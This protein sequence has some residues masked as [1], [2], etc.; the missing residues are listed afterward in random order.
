MTII[1]EK[2]VASFL[3]RLGT[4][5]IKKLL[6]ENNSTVLD[7][8]RISFFEAQ[9]KFHKKYG[10]KYGKEF[11]TFLADNANF[12]KFLT[13]F[14]FSK[15]ILSEND[16]SPKG[17]DGV[18]DVSSEI[19][20]DFIAMANAEFE[21][22]L[23]LKTHFGLQ[24]IITTQSADHSLL[25]KIIEAISKPSRNEL[26]QKLTQI[27]QIDI[28]DV[29][30]RVEELETVKKL[31]EKS[32]KLVLVNGLGGIGKTTMAKAF[33]E[34]YKNEFAHLVWINASP[35]LLDSVLGEISLIDNLD[36]RMELNA[37]IEQKKNGEAY[38]LLLNRMKR[39]E[40]NNLL[41][42]D[43]VH[44]Q[45]EQEL[46]ILTGHLA[47]TWKTLLTSRQE[48]PDCRKYPLDILTPD[49]AKE[50][51]LKH[52]DREYDEND[53]DNLLRHIGYHTLTIE[54]LSKTANKNFTL[55]IKTILEYLQ[56]H[57]LNHQQ[58]AL[59]IKVAHT[60][61]EVEVYAHLLS[62]FDLDQLNTNEQ[63]LLKQ[64]SLLPPI[65]IEQE[66]LYEY[67]SITEKTQNDFI[68]TLNSLYQKGF[69]NRNKNFYKA[70]QIIQE[71]ALYKFELSFEDCEILMEYFSGKLSLDQAKDNPVDK[72]PF[73]E[74]G[75]Y[76]YKNLELI[77]INKELK[78]VQCEHYSDFSSNLAAVYRDL[79]RYVQ[80]ADLFEKA[81]KSDIKNFGE[82]HP[83]IAINQSN[84]ATVYRDLGRYDQAADLFEK[85]LKSDIKNFGENHPTVAICQ[86]N[87]GAVYRDLG[88]YDQAVEL[89]EKA[90]QSDIKNFGENHPTV[91][92]CQ[93]N[94]ALVYKDLGRYYEAVKLIERVF[95]NSI[96]NFGENHPTVAV[97]R[98]NLATMYDSL[99]RY[100]QAAEL[101]ENALK[102]NITNLGENHPTVAIIRSNL[103]LAYT[104][105]GRYVQAVDLLEK[106]MKSDIKNF[107]ENHHVVAISRSNLATVYLQL[108]K[109]KVALDLFYKAKT[110]FLQTFGENHPHT[111]TVQRWINSIT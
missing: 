40:G 71:V 57:Q 73:A 72:F 33:I 95:Q 13:S 85:A 48:I 9:N 106:A 82:N 38:E 2:I 29:V 35:I 96:K 111:K 64:F 51:F 23:F 110:T 63:F 58:L 41:V 52:F 44:L 7:R 103:A 75:F 21:N 20:D 6:S 5:G 47:G 3:I 14:D 80:A 78:P 79:G 62:I 102:S 45:D 84:I 74:Y 42:L 104:G 1:L 37:L 19:V 97:S 87:L 10:D 24:K 98:S 101:L 46:K 94:L 90:L 53:L 81:L 91:A 34:N 88:R 69:L 15:P 4:E 55:S 61:E 43:N 28:T 65:E 25:E 92:I 36:L 17:F 107:G 77:Q 26:P 105:L 70:H 39:I 32:D 59:K 27:P 50:L 30:G 67:L 100:D 99:G 108:N 56:K 109:K 66:K 93:S 49:K 12:E 54:L 89:L 68:S 16:F 76:L 11:S 31:L 18:P 83:T 60:K 8:M 86:S 22:D